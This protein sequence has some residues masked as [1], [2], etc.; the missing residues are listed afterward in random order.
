MGTDRDA[1]RH[2]PLSCHL[3]QRSDGQDRGQ[4]RHCLVHDRPARRD[5]RAGAQHQP[6]DRG[7]LEHPGTARSEAHGRRVV[8]ELPGGGSGWRRRRLGCSRFPRLR[9]HGAQRRR[10]AEDLPGLSLR[11]NRRARASRTA[12]FG[13]SSCSASCTSVPRSTA[14]RCSIRRAIPSA[15]RSTPSTSSR[16]A[17]SRRRA[18]PPLPRSCSQT[19]PTTSFYF[20]SSRWTASLT[21]S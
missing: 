20:T 11:S 8:G 1:E 15:T 12:G 19:G 16:S 5:A 13:P 14:R 17:R 9:L 18:T 6:Q 4:A 2:R 10:S 21:C 7:D 3:D